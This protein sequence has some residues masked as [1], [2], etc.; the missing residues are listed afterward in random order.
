MKRIGTNAGG[1]PCVRFL[2]YSPQAPEV[3]PL[4]LDPVYR[5]DQVFGR[6]RAVVSGLDSRDRCCQLIEIP[7]EGYIGLVDPLA[8]RVSIVYQGLDFDSRSQAGS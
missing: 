1:Y 4:A 7:I 6:W 5:S 8:S 3:L 2:A